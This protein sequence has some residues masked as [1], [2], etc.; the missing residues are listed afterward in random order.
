MFHLTKDSYGVA[1]TSAIYPHNDLLNTS[2]YLLDGIESKTKAGEQDGITLDCIACVVVSAAAAEALVN[3]IGSLR[4]KGWNERESSPK[5]IE[6]ICAA[7][8]MPLDND[9]APFST[10]K[11]LRGLRNQIMHCQP[12]VSDGAEVPRDENN[13]LDAVWLSSMTPEFCREAYDSIKIFQKQMFIELKIGIVE[14]S[15]F[16]IWDIAE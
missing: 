13:P 7:A 2:K 16:A 12:E 10:L 11:K 1:M 6:I 14:A 3:A 5:K 9:S 8:K 15:S 4:V